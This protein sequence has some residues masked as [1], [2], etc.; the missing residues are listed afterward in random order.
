MKG[1]EIFAQGTVR[2]VCDADGRKT[3]LRARQAAETL[4][5]AEMEVFQDIDHEIRRIMVHS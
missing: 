3:D 1:R 2:A 5:L 4:T